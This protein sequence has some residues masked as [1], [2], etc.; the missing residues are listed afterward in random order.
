MISILSALTAI[1]VYMRLTELGHAS[2]T[3]A[4][5]GAIVGALAH[6]AFIT[7]KKSAGDEAPNGQNK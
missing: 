3:A 6:K 4:L 2:I 5:C 1:A 7:I